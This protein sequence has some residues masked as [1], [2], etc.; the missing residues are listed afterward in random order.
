MRDRFEL[1]R[2]W[3][4][5]RIRA[6]LVKRGSPRAQ[7]TA[8]VMAA[9]CAG[10]LCSFCLLHLGLTVMWLRYGLAIATAYGTFLILIGTW[11]ARQR[12]KVAER[13]TRWRREITVE[14]VVDIVTDHTLGAAAD[15]AEGVT[16][17]VSSID[18]AATDEASHFAGAGGQFG[19]GGATAAFDSADVPN[20][21]ASSS[22]GD[23]LDV[24]F[25]LDLDDALV[26]VAILAALAAALAA[27][28]WVVI[29]APTLF[30]E[31]LFDA[32][33]S[34]GL[35]RRLRRIDAAEWW[36][37]AIRLTWIPAL[38]TTITF[39]A[40][41]YVMQCYA[42]EAA[43]IGA[44]WQHDELAPRPQHPTTRSGRHAHP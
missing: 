35:Y 15:A 38:L 14:D 30:A 2:K 12:R 22:L 18:P 8:F 43:S 16:R 9:G 36:R 28:V 27:S 34:A 39:A 37:S 44:V 23:G 41:G 21:E 29:S 6:G 20:G 32:A 26:I 4:V 24:S 11:V 31:V 13:E 17:L 5:E 7:M 40:A 25:N 19:G 3:A 33:L 10:F 1:K 42:P